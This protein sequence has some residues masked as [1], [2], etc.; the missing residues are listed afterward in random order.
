MDILS[1][2]GLVFGLGFI[3]YSIIMGDGFTDIDL[4]QFGQFVDPPSIMIV[5]GGTI[6]A[7][8]VSFPLKSF[9]KIPK[10]LKVIFAPKKYNPQEYIE[11]IVFFAKE[12]RINGLLALE[13]KLS[14]TKDKF[15]KNSILLVV[16]SVE[17]EKVRALLNKELDYLDDRHSQDMAFYAKASDYAPGFGMI[18]TLIGLINLLA[19]LEDTAALTANM[20]VALVTTFYGS[21]L[22]NLIFK[23]IASK[24]K[25][26][27]EEEYL[28]KMIISEGVQAIQDGD[29]PNFI[30][31]KLTRLLPSYSL[32]GELKD[33]NNGNK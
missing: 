25:V 5:L 30:Q 2:L 3:F 19:N 28:C 4:K 12:A 27:H 11:Q 13:D 31:E 16:D 21:L 18:G 26:R 1:I 29:N 17:P 20:A 14:E 8:M 6:A 10:H 33:A 22:S 32:K 15:L 7:L 23:P 9:A 24:L